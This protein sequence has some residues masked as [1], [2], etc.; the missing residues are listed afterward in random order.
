MDKVTFEVLK[1][2]VAHQESKYSFDPAWP[3][4]AGP[5]GARAVRRALPDDLQINAL[6]ELAKKIERHRGAPQDIEWAVSETGDVHVLQ[7]R[8]ETVWSQRQ[9]EQLVTEKKS[10]VSHV[11]ARFAG[12]GVVGGKGPGAS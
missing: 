7:V 4:R 12:V 2:T 6:A 11:L 8:P 1:R 10:A 5:G 9:A 3:R